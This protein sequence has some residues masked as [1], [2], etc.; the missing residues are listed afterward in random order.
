MNQRYSGF[1][2]ES[3]HR[4]EAALRW[5]CCPE[6]L[7]FLLFGSW[8]CR[9]FLFIHPFDIRRHV[10]FFHD[11]AVRRLCAFASLTGSLFSIVINIQR[12]LLFTTTTTNSNE[13]KKSSTS[14][15]GSGTS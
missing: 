11:F 7:P 4:E 2:I 12:P 13:K 14:T 6:I 9:Y 8:L 15:V 5:M 1:S 10:I 3:N